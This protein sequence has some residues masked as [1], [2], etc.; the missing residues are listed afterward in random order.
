MSLFRSSAVIAAFTLLSRIFGFVR[1]VVIANMMGAGMQA[2]AFF[3]A[4]KIPNFLRRL[5]AE[6]AFNAAFLPMFAGMLKVEGRDHALRFASSIMTYLT[7]ILLVLTTIAII[8]MP[9]VVKVIAPGFQHHPELYTLTIS[10]TR[11]TFPYLLCI[12]LVSLL[13]GVLNS[14]DKF[15]AVAFTPVL[16]N[17]CLISAILMLPEHVGSYA[18][19]LSVGVLVAGTVQLVWLIAVNLKYR[20]FPGFTRPQLTPDVRRMLRNIMPVAFGAGVAQVNQMIDVI[21]ATYLDNAVS[22]LYYAD[23]LYELPLGVIGIAVATAMLPMLSRH[24][25]AGETQQAMHL[26]DQSIRFVLLIGLPASVALIMLAVPIIQTIYQH[27]A[28]SAADTH[29]VAPALIAYACGLPSFLLIKIFANSFFAAT[30]TKTPVKIAVICM[31]TNLMLNL[32][33]IEPLEHVGLAIA[34]SVAGWLNALLLGTILYR[35]GTFHPSYHLLRTL[36]WYLLASCVMAI[37][38][39]GLHQQLLA[40]WYHQGVFMQSAATMLLVM[41]GTT[42]YFGLLT[43]CNILSISDLK[44]M[45][46]KS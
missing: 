2:D 45:I 8:F 41:A 9:Y 38:L 1:D 7:L 23:R 44:K 13:S 35:R 33:L 26:I 17:I 11:I 3:I 14:H 19:A 43:F 15:A 34:T 32:L 4:F 6:G 37:G 16:L 18:Y 39:Y 24:I 25:R 40:N 5:F 21:L 27:G 20:T 22:F 30:D 31:F 12:S 28:F 29:Q 46:K 42:L 10:L 36:G